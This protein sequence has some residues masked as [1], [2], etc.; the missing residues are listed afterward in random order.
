MQEGG[1]QKAKNFLKNNGAEDFGDYK[2]SLAKKYASQL[3]SKVNS[4]T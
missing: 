1:N 2:G 3:E 4:R